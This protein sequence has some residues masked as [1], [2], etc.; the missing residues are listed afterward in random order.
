MTI[1]MFN[2]EKR[3][4]VAVIDE[5]QMISNS[6]RGHAWTTAILGLQASEIHL[7]G[8]PRAH[9]LIADICKTTGDHFEARHY[10]RLSK[11]HIA[12]KCI[13]AIKD[14]SPGDCII[15]FSR[16]QIFGLKEA[17]NEKAL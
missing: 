16:K 12:D 15:T 11:L 10:Q 9:K 3:Y 1:E 8:D 6:N 13:M 17:I 2:P 5:V 7:C 4:D 14:L